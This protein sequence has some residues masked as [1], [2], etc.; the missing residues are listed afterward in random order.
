MGAASVRRP[1]PFGSQLAIIMHDGVQDRGQHPSV[2]TGAWT[3]PVQNE[4]CNWSVTY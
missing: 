2:R 4:L 1:V 3:K